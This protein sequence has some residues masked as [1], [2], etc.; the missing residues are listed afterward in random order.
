[1]QSPQEKGLFNIGK[2]LIFTDSVLIGVHQ[3]FSFSHRP[4]KTADKRRCTEKDAKS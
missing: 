2:T 4:L 1:V 3:R